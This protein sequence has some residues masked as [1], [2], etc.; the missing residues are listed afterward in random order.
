MYALCIHTPA[1]VSLVRLFET[2]DAR[3]D[4]STSAATLRTATPKRVRVRVRCATDLATTS[5]KQAPTPTVQ[6]VLILPCKYACS[7]ALEA[8]PL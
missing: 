8:A 5:L 3:P 4:H 2:R 7:V 1:D 6:S